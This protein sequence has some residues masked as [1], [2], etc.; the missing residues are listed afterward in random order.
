MIT[1]CD[2]H[3]RV[4][5]FS[6]KGDRWA[7]KMGL[8][9]LRPGMKERCLLATRQLHTCLLENSGAAASF[10]WPCLVKEGE[11]SDTKTGEEK[12]GGKEGERIVTF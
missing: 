5:G 2:S 1:L 9:A 12:Q 6:H 8:A 3:A 4:L 10:C 7:A 11:Q